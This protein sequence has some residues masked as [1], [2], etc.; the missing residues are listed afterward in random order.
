[1]TVMPFFAKWLKKNKLAPE[2]IYGFHS[3][4]FGSMEHIEKVLELSE[5][6]KK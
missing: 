3:T 1:M 4:M 5:K 6:I 2:R